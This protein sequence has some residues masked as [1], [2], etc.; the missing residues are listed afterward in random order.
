MA[1]IFS[2]IETTCSYLSPEMALVIAEYDFWKGRLTNHFFRTKKESRMDE[3]GRPWDAL[4]SASWLPGRKA[5]MRIDPNGVDVRIVSSYLETRRN[6]QHLEVLQP[7]EDIPDLRAETVDDSS[8]NAVIRTN[9]PSQN[10]IVIVS[11]KSSVFTMGLILVELFGGKR[12]GLTSLTRLRNITDIFLSET[13]NAEFRIVMEWETPNSGL[14]VANS[15][16]TGLTSSGSTR[17]PNSAQCLNSLGKCTR[18]KQYN[19]YRIRSDGNGP[20]DNRHKTS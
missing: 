1:P 8:D 5:G 13:G 11:E 14:D 15:C 12:T 9:D 4:L 18:W 17:C 7:V 19:P 16:A 20:L 3:T 6:F 2:Q 10:D